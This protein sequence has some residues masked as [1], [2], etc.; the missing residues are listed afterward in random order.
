[1]ASYTQTLL[2]VSGLVTD[3][4]QIRELDVNPFLLGETAE[5]SMAVDARIRIDP[6]AFAAR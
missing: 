2:R 4:E 5:E 3:F 6:A 1:V